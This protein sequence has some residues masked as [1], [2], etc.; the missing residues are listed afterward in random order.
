MNFV[1]AAPLFPFTTSQ[2]P[3]YD[4]TYLGTQ[5][6]DEL[7]VY[8]FNVTPRALDRAHAYF[9]GVVWVDQ[10][11]S[12]I[13]KTIGKWVSE[14]GDVTSTG[15]SVYHVRNLPGRSGQEEVV[16]HVF[17]IGFLL[18]SGNT[19]VPI[20]MITQWSKYMKGT[21]PAVRCLRQ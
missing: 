20:R 9:S 12:S 21:L 7:S 6:L 18:R 15:A 2:L 16:P 8:I 14:T 13:V 5:P 10:Q 11:D 1:D 4:I 3:K 17:A 19:H